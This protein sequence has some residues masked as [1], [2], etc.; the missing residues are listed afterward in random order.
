MYGNITYEGVL[1]ASSEAFD[2]LKKAYSE[3]AL[4]TKEIDEV[5][6]SYLN[7]KKIIFNKIFI[8]VVLV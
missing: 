4:D 8:K 2:T 5:K 6:D 7:N 3:Y 1:G